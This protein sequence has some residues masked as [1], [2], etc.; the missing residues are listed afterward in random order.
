[1]NNFLLVDDHSIVRSGIKVLIRENFS[2]ISIGEAENSSQIKE[3]ISQR[4]YDLVMLDINL[5]DTDFIS[6]LQWMST[7][8]IVKKVLVFTTHTDDIYGVRSIQLGVGGFVNK[9]APDHEIVNAIRLVLA[10][11]KYV[12]PNLAQLLLENNTEQKAANPFLLLSPREMEIIV[13]M[14]RGKSLPEISQ[15]L[16]IH[17]STANTY[18]RRI[19]EKLNIVNV[20]SLT[21]L[22]QTYKV[23][24]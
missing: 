15:Q 1:M 7:K 4:E 14:N 21:K 22:M 11:R 8:G 19:F 20:V 23:G 13:L 17:Y 2:A 16:N 9:T 6:L 5:P 24:E 18:K 3:M 10:G 12:S